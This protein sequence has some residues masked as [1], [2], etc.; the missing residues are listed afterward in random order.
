MSMTATM[1]RQ[2]SFRSMEGHHVFIS[3]A[4]GSRLDD[5][6]LVSAGHGRAATLWISDGETDSMIKASDVVDLWEKVA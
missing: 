6:E 1:Q 3:L 2:R 4:D 5:V